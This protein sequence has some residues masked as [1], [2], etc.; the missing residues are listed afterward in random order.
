MSGFFSS[1]YWWA[2][3]HPA[4]YLLAVATVISLIVG[5][6]FIEPFLAQALA[7]GA[8]LLLSIFTTAWQLML[9]KTLLGS[10]IS[11]A[12]SITSYLAAAYL[13]LFEA[14]AK[15]TA[16]RAGLGVTILAA[17][18]L[19]VF[20]PLIESQPE[21]A[22]DLRSRAS[23]QNSEERHYMDGELFVDDY[24]GNVYSSF[25]YRDAIIECASEEEL[26]L[27]RSQKRKKPHELNRALRAN[28]CLRA[29]QYF[30]DYGEDPPNLHA[31]RAVGPLT[32]GEAMLCKIVLSEAGT[33][34]DDLRWALDQVN[35]HEMASAL[36]PLE[37]LAERRCET[38]ADAVTYVRGY[39]DKQHTLMP[40]LRFL[41]SYQRIWELAWGGPLSD[42]CLRPN[43]PTPA[44]RVLRESPDIVF[45][46]PNPPEVLDFTPL[47]GRLKSIVQHWRSP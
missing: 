24:G 1:T 27:W 13:V 46:L 38:I 2:R 20:L 23:R 5:I 31:V 36:E 33:Y 29:L 10:L 16:D 41:N 6:A 34:L 43:I 17:F 22:R 37:R 26:D 45:L 3:S 7:L 39:Y 40:G 30:D 19:V 28:W 14:L 21:A 32:L 18:I 47:L 8:L 35:E 9:P 42:L 25:S 4:L 11:L 12:V 44:H 15:T